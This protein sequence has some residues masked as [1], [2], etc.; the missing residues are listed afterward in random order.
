MLRL[1]WNELKKMKRQKTVGIIV[2]IGILLPAFC[3]VLCVKNH[4]R[5]RNLVGM[6]MQFGRSLIAP[7]IFSVLLLTMFSLEE[8]N[9]TWKN[10]LTTGISQCSLFLAK[11]MMAL[12]FVVL[13]AAVNTG[14]TMAGGI[15]LRNYNPDFIKVF[16][17]LTISALAAAA[18]T[19][20]A[21]CLI[22]L[23]RKKYPVAMIV[24]NIFV[25]SNFILVWQLTMFRCLNLSLPILI[26]YRIIYPISILDY[27]DNLQAGLEIL[28]YPAGKGTLILALTAI[29]SILIGAG[30]VRR[31][32]V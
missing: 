31:Q 25:I 3:T 10:I 7:F 9:N 30:I 17:V 20:P 21:V 26:A 23:L 14:Y 24:T 19:M 4:Y 16:A 11:L 5:F 15:V 8:Q 6:N 27:T 18:G 12:T 22:V 28:Y 29:A 1:Y 32:E 13:F 2:L